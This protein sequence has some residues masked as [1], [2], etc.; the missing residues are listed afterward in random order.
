ME[1]MNDFLVFLKA[2]REV[3]LWALMVILLLIITLVKVAKRKPKEGRK[4]NARRLF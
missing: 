2:Y 3:A 4:K 1:N